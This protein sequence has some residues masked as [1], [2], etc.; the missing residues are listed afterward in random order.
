MTAE[1]ES[2]RTGHIAW[3]RTGT[4]IDVLLLHGATDDGTCW[5]P[6]VAALAP[7]WNVLTL[8]ARGHGDSGLPDG[9]AGPAEQ[10]SDAAMVL[11]AQELRGGRVVVGGHSMGAGTAIA[12]AQSRPDLVRAL[13]LE[14][15]GLRSSTD[16]PVPHDEPPRTLPK[17]LLEMR[18]MSQAERVAKGRAE[19]PTWPDDELPGWASSKAKVSTEFLSHRP[20]GRMS[21][22]LSRAT[23][24]PVLLIRGDPERG[25]IVTEAAAKQA[26]DE[27]AGRIDVVHIPGV[28]HSIRREARDRYLVEV[29]AFLAA[30]PA[31]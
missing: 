28:G 24:C 6:I 31:G 19:N 5:D 9:P 21:T 7:R 30:H 29:A 2:G 27:G 15:P 13:V 1:T 26:A 16:E 20:G 12:L 23:S 22:N 17:S 14:D 4:P 11:E 10:A 18:E 3:T 8:D 25:S